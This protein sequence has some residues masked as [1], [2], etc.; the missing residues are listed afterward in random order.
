MHIDWIRATVDRKLR[1][2]GHI[3]TDARKRTYQ[4]KYAK[5]DSLK[6]L[7]NMY[8]SDTVICLNRKR[9][10]IEAALKIAEKKK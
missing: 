6:I 10:K 2:T 8:Y 4:L 7:K 5:S 9:S 1:V 3:T